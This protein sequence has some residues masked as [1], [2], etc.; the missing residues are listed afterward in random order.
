MQIGSRRTFQWDNMKGEETLK[1]NGKVEKVLQYKL[2]HDLSL[3]IKIQFLTTIAKQFLMCIECQVSFEERELNGAGNPTFFGTPLSASNY[4]AS[5]NRSLQQQRL[6][7]SGSGRMCNGV[8]NFVDGIPSPGGRAYLVSFTRI[9]RETEW[10]QNTENSTPT[11]NQRRTTN[12]TGKQF[13]MDNLQ[14]H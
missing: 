4:S 6:P 11:E 10:C 8:I 13:I 7:P 1:V 12:S 14:L 2:I 3:T 5:S 9:A